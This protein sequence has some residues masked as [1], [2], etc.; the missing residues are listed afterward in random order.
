MCKTNFIKAAKNLRGIATAKMV[1]QWRASE[2]ITILEAKQLFDCEF[3]VYQYYFLR[4]YSTLY[5]PKFNL[6]VKL[7]TVKVV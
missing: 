6:G 2:K 1:E 4:L 7:R 5:M 3:W